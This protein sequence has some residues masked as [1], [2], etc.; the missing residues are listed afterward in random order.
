MTN[1]KENQSFSFVAPKAE[2][3]ESNRLDTVENIPTGPHP[4]ILYGIVDLGTH[5]ED[6]KG[7]PK[8]N[9]KVKFLFELPLFQQ[10]FYQDGDMMPS[11]VTHK[12]N[13]VFSERSNLKKFVEDALGITLTENDYNGGYDIGKLLGKAFIIHIEHAPNKKDPKKVWE[14]IKAIEP[15]TERSKQ[16]Y[17]FQWDDVVNINPYLTFVIDP[18]MKN[19]NS[20]SFARLWRNDKKALKESE[21]GL[22]YA[23]K[24]GVFKEKLDDDTSAPAD[25]K[26]AST[27]DSEEDIFGGSDEV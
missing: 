13:N 4:A 15:I 1:I 12:L 2:G 8:E 21:E 11:V 3:G 27:T 18:E 20:D 22:E 14:N 16:I 25:D 5:K 19:F 26:N 24:G 7:T 9:R 6:Y 10:V 23:R 17:A